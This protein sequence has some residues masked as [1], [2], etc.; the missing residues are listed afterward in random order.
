MNYEL[1]YILSPKLSDEDAEKKAK[2][3]TEKFKENITE[4]VLEDFWGK[5]DLAYPINKFEHGYYVMLQFKAEKD[6]INKIEAKIKLDD[7]IIRHLIVK[8]DD[9]A[10]MKK[11]EEKADEANNSEKI[12]DIGKEEKAEVS[13]ILE[14]N[15]LESEETTKDAATTETQKSE[16]LEETEK[17]KGDPKKKERKK[18]K[19]DISDLDKKLDDI[20]DSEIDD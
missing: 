17:A 8:K 9:F 1:V 6:S 3:L 18:T 20:L 16:G 14:K 15:D 11:E 4:I 7:E 12:D 5:R 2:D 10:P 13:E 19:A